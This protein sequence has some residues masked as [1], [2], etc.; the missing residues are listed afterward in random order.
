M[1]FALTELGAQEYGG[2]WLTTGAGNW[3]AQAMYLALGFVVVDGST[4]FH[5][6][7]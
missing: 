2:V 3:P 7:L 5:K 1:S 6:D 4:C